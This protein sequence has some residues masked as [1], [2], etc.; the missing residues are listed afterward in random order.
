MN[1]IVTGAGKGIGF[2][3]CKKL[4]KNPKHHVLAISRNTK[5]LIDLKTNYS[6]LTPFAFDLEQDN[7][8]S[9]AKTLTGKV[10]ILINNAGLLIHKTFGEYQQLELD[11]MM[12]VNFNAPFKLIQALLSYF[13]AHA[14]IVNISSMGGF[15]GS[16]KFAGLSAYSASKAALACLTECL[17]E[18]LKIKK[19]KVNCLCLGSV[20]TEMLEQ[21]FP[22][23]AASMQPAEIAEFIAD[24]ALNAHHYLNGKIIPVSLSTP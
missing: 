7:F 24:F 14:H 20:Q 19:I 16:A 8:D 13:S 17:A 18:E 10:D 5:A 6:N 23:Y 11:R 12:N 1:I 15:Q 21:A 3:V 4:L 22:G 2:E 9:I